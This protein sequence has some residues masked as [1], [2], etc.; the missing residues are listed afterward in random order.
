ME[1]VELFD[2]LEELLADGVRI[3]LTG[4]VMVNED[5]VIEI[6]EHIRNSLP[7][8]LHQAKWVLKERQRLL[9]EAEKEAREIVEQ[10][11]VYTTKL[12]DQNEITQQARLQ[13]E[14]IIKQAKETSQEIRAGAHEYAE[15][16]LGRLEF[17]LS[18]TME[19]V[20]RG[21]VELK[22]D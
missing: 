11:K 4:K 20:Q 16:V 13:A 22:K 7:E 10:G 15:Q 2:N 8:E 19:A 14:E 18:S 6:L 3:P 12:I 17:F 21:R 5:E 9:A 1:I